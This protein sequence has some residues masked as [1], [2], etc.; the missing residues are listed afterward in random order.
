MLL[1]R[2]AH[3][4]PLRTKVSSSANPFLVM[5]ED[6]ASSRDMSA[7]AQV[8][9][10]AVAWRSAVA[11]IVRVGLCPPEVGKTAPSAT[12]KLSKWWWRPCSS[13]TLVLALVPIGIPPHHVLSRRHLD[14]S[15]DVRF[16]R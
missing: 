12:K 7:A 4:S 11:M 5:A 3:E 13:V 2:E 10:Q 15:R 9:A 14:I 6:R 8:P 1:I 16:A